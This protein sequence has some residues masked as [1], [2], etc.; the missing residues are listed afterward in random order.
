MEENIS[1]I[2]SLILSF[3]KEE[4]SESEKKML[5]DWI[6]ADLSNKEHF[7]CMYRIWNAASN[8]K[9]E[10]NEVELVLQKMKYQMNS[11]SSELDLE[12]RI[13]FN[14]IIKWAAV[15][16][17]SCITGAFG[18]KYLFGEVSVSYG[19]F[20]NEIT[21]PLGSK[22]NIR[23]PDGT[24]VILNAGSKLTYTM[25][26][27]K[28]LR[29]VKLVGEGYFKVA[30]NKTV[31]F[32]VNTSKA[33]IEALGTE[34]NVKAYPE[35]NIIETV[36]VKGSVLVSEIPAKGNNSPKKES[37]ILHPG[38]KVQIYKEVEVVQEVPSESKPKSNK[39]SEKLVAHNELLVEKSE[40][41]TE[42]SWKDTRWIIKG[43]DL[44][45][46]A[47]IL[48]RRFNV[49]IYLAD[50]GLKQYRFSGTIENETIEEVFNIMK[51]TIP[52]S[53]TIEKGKV[54]WK[55]NKNLEKVY[56]ESY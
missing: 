26:Y 10:S 12:P 47:V 8:D 33:K 24:D 37:I 19:V 53:Y 18:Y 56:K 3:L 2:D 48:S 38:E 23:L 49:S 41:E 52:I 29:E 45:N 22:S 16:L 43:A 20:V 14:P 31:P 27:G 17:I 50:E 6:N 28:E 9:Q 55:I 46:L 7:K 4:I 30:E 25:D 40:V 21:V 32:I 11:G 1:Y 13:Y 39:L 51:F 44:E 35:E 34:F 36:L 5:E 42:T 15:V 54:T